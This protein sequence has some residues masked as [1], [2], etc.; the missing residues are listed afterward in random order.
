MVYPMT[1]EELKSNAYQT[2]EQL[3]TRKALSAVLQPDTNNVRRVPRLQ[4]NTKNQTR[5]TNKKL[6]VITNTSISGTQ[7]EPPRVYVIGRSMSYRVNNSQELP[8]RK[9]EE[10]SHRVQL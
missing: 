3:S 10:F 1:Y 6:S 2:T 9:I 8:I 5:A 4:A 7:A